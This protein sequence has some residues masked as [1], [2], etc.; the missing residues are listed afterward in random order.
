MYKENPPYIVAGE[1]VRTTRMYAMSV[2]P[3]RKDML[4]RISPR[5]EGLIGQGAAR[6]ETA[7]RAYGSAGPKGASS[8]RERGSRR[9]APSADETTEASAGSRRRERDFTNKIKIAS[10]VFDLAV[11]KKKKKL[12][13]LDW[14]R[15][16]KVREELDRDSLALYKGLKGVVLLGRQ[17]LLDGERL[18]LILKIAPWLD[19]EADLGREWPRK[20]NFHVNEELSELIAALGHVMQVSRARDKT[21]EL[22]FVALFT[23]SEGAY[24]FRCSRGFHTA[25]NESVA[26]LECLVDEL[27]EGRSDEDREKVS[28]LYRKLSSFFE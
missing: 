18:D 14:R 28:S 26:S 20:R 21:G 8:E 5:L 24:W 6:T 3:L 11:D 25:I 23:D 16:R 12:V 15:L 27:G 2:S 1:I 7:D 17:R 13:E 4:S 10:E 19:L 9:A 22:G